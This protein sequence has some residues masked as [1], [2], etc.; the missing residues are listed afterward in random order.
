M[1]LFSKPVSTTH[2]CDIKLVTCAQNRSSTYYDFFDN[3]NINSIE[4]ETSSVSNRTTLTEVHIRLS[5]VQKRESEVEEL[6]QE[7]LE[8]RSSCM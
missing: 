3:I 1:W 2:S 8:R 4:Y 6:Q 7:M 5:K